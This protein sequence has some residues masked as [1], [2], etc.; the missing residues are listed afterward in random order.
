MKGRRKGSVLLKERVAGKED[1]PFLIGKTNAISP[2]RIAHS[3]RKKMS[4]GGKE[5]NLAEEEASS[6]KRIQHFS[7][8]TCGPRKG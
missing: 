8:K 5:A 7:Q 2:C 4:E 6:R 1:T 3:Y